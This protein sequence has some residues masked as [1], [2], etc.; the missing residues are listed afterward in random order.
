MKLP[1][2]VKRTELEDELLKR[3]SMYEDFLEYIGYMYDIDI[4]DLWTRF[5]E[6]WRKEHL[7]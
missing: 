3:L 2:L 7:Q 4:L 1:K 6:H 5:K